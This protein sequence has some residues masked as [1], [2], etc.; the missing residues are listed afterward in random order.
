MIDYG[1]W[2]LEADPSKVGSQNK[3]VL[4]NSKKLDEY[5]LQ[6]VKIIVVTMLRNGDTKSLQILIKV[7]F[8]Y[9]LIFDGLPTTHMTLHKKI[10]QKWSYRK[11]FLGGK[12]LS[13][14]NSFQKKSLWL[15]A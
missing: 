13:L 12:N 2:T 5:F 8:C 7:S 1:K 15:L 14:V 10:K 4:K 9:E 11:H 3:H 6:V